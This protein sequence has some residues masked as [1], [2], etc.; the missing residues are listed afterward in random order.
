[1]V[2][3]SGKAQDWRINRK[4]GEADPREWPRNVRLPVSHT[5]VYPKVL[6][7]RKGVIR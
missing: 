1:M 5:N 6:S 4:S 3:W 2:G 7:K